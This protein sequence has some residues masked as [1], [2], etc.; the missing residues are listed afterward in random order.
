MYDGDIASVLLS[1]QEISDKVGELARQVAA[2]YPAGGDDLVLITVLK[3]AVMF[4]SD[5][6]RALPVPVQLEFMAVSS[7]GSSTSSSGVV[8]ILKDLDRDIADRD[9]LIVEDIIDS[10]LTLSWL[11]KNLASRKPRSMEVC[12]LLRKPDAVKVDVPVKYVGFDIPNEFVVGYGLDYAERY[13]DLPYIGKL[14]P[15]VYSG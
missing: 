2:D 9:V 4:T 8:R 3:G 11:L 13:R 7:Y 14:D 10:G 5:L 6:A 1:E 12:T 15:K